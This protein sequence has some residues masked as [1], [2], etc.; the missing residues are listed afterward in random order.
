ML[1]ILQIL[2]LPFLGFC[3]VAMTAAFGFMTF[4]DYAREQHKKKDA[5][6][7]NNKLK[8]KGVRRRL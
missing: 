8:A 2:S 4:R 7:G 5:A 3:F 1:N 6:K